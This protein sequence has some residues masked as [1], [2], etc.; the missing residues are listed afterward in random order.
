MHKKSQQRVIP[1]ENLKDNT[2]NLIYF[3]PCKL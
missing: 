1:T 3:F 2:D